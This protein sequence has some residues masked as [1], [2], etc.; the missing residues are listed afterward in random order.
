MKLKPVIAAVALGLV[1]NI[2]YA[3][4][5]T[6]DGEDKGNLDLMFKVMTIV[7]GK[8]NGFDPNYGTSELL[9]MKYTTPSFNGVRFSAGSYITGDLLGTNDNTLDADQKLARGMYVTNDQ[10]AEQLL[11][12]LHLKGQHGSFDWFAGRV[13]YDSP[14]TTA[15]VSTMP[16]FHTGAGATFKVNE[17]F[18]VG[19]AQITQIAF[20]ARAATE[21]GL[22]GEGTGTAGT[23]INPLDKQAEFLD[24]ADATIANNTEN[25]NGITT[26]NASYK[27][28][29]NANISLWNYYAEDISNNVYVSADNKFPLA[30]KRAIKVELQYLNQTNVGADLAGDLDYSLAGAKATYITPKWSAY[31]AAN[32]SFGDTKMLNAWGGDPAYTSSIF[33]RNAYRENVTA[34]KV[35]AKYKITPKWILSAS[36]ADY[37]QSDTSTATLTPS[38]DATEAN[39]TLVWKMNKNTLFKLFHSSRTSEYDTDSNDRTQAHTRLAAVV[40]F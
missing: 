26:L 14:L 32:N 36:Y 35:G 30:D 9:K 3:K 33:S 25:T 17:S 13:I 38:S 2:A 18:K 10:S 16:N 7:D 34:F 20:G 19:L 28:G 11:G 37:G 8:D 31:V 22:I 23:A 40:K 15:A 12:E 29:K 4:N 6:I 5:I 39:V 1:S 24:I 21:W 27:L